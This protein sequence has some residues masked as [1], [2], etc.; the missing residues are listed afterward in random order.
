VSPGTA[1]R[2]LRPAQTIVTT[3]ARDLMTLMLMMM[4]VVVVMQMMMTMI[5]K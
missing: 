3:S 4:L 2:R 1:D 5:H